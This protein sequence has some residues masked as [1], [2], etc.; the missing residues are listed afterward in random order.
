MYEQLG[1][2]CVQRIGSYMPPDSLSRFRNIN[3]FHRRELKSVL[4]DAL[5]AA[6]NS[7]EELCALVAATQFR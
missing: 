4:V 5:V 3:R 7:D 6:T 1:A 2:G